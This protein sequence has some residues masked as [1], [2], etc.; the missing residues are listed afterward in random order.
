MFRIEYD[1]RVIIKFLLNEGADA[2]DIADKL[3]TQFGEHAYK[4]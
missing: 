2:R 1:Q 4:L 3:Q